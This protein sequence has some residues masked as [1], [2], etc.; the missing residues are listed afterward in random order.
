M[1]CLDLKV[2]KLLLLD[3]MWGAWCLIDKHPAAAPVF[4][5]LGM[6]CLTGENPRSK[7]F[8]YRHA[9]L[10]PEL[11]VDRNQHKLRESIQYEGPQVLLAS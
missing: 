2:E 9:L 1:V 7:N 6:S 10:G 5:R 11:E 3:G 8:W 4:V